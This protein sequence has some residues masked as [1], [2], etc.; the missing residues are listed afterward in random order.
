M[1]K[2]YW[3]YRD[4]DLLEVDLLVQQYGEAERVIVSGDDN[5]G[6]YYWQ[7]EEGFTGNTP[8][9]IVY[10][11]NEHCEPTSKPK[12]Y[13]FPDPDTRMID[14]QNVYVADQGFFVTNDPDGAAGC[15]IMYEDSDG[16]ILQHKAVVNLHNFMVDR[17]GVPM[18]FECFVYEGEFKP[19]KVRL[20][21]RDHNDKK[22][23]AE[24]DWFYI[25]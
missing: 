18:D 3:N 25:V 20:I 17:E 7:I 16:N 1:V 10:D 22:V 12:I 9:E 2:W 24:S 23:R 5:H 15:T 11:E 21:V 19:Q 4:N 8:L 14:P 13:V 6:F